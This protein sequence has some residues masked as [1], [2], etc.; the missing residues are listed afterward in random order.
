MNSI[1]DLLDLEVANAIISDILTQGQTKTTTL[2]TPP[3][4]HC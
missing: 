4:A 1:T 3:A 2:K